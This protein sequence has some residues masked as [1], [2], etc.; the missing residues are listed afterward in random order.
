[1]PRSD[2]S[3]AVLLLAEQPRVFQAHLLLGMAYLAKREPAKAI[4]A[5]RTL[6]TLAPKEPRGP[7]LI[8]IALRAQGK[9]AEAK[10][11]FEAA[12]ALAPGYAESR[13]VL[14]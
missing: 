12:L 3:R 2:A 9:P 1:M 8:G 11:Q 14:L 7:Y 6:V 13:K 10:K 5:F 4:E